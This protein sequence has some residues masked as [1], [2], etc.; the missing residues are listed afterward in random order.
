MLLDVRATVLPR[1][2]AM[3]QSPVLALSRSTSIRLGSNHRSLLCRRA[4]AG[5]IELDMASA[6]AATAAPFVNPTR[7][8]EHSAV[9]AS[10]VQ[11]SGCGLSP[12]MMRTPIRVSPVESVA[13]VKP[14]PRAII[15]IG[16]SNDDADH[17]R[18]RVVD[19]PRWRWRWRVTISRRGRAVRFDHLSPRIRAQC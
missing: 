9:A 17:R 15:T 3:T 7:F 5:S 12:V 1:K 19:R 16:W 8:P 18:R 6:S 2:L 4:F 14:E 13:T 11:R 10:R